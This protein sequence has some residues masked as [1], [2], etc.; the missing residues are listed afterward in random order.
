MSDQV[1][2]PL[3][4]DNGSA[5]KRSGEIFGHPTCL[6]TLFF[7][8]MW[9]RFSFYGM[10]ALLILYMVN[11]LFWKQEGASHVMAWYAGLVYATPVI[12]GI[13]ADKLIGARWAVVVGGVIIAIGHFLLAFEPM[14]FFYSG[15]GC[16]IVG[17]GF[18]KPNISTQVGALYR[19]NDERR[20]S[21][22]TIFYMGINLGAFI[23]PLVCGWLRFNY[24]YHYGFAAA[25]V[26]MVLGLIVYIWGMGRVVRRE[27]Q[28]A[29]EEKAA[30]AGRE[31]PAAAE[32]S[33]P[34]KP[35]SAGGPSQSRVYFDRG[36]VLVVICVFA[37][38]FWVGFEQAANVMNLWADKHT[39]LH[40]F[41]DQA[42]M[43][44]VNDVTAAAAQPSND[45]VQSSGGGIGNWQM[46]AEQSQ[47]INPLFIIIFAGVFAWLWEFLDRRGKQPSTPMKMAFGVFFLSCAYG[48]MLL[49]AQAEN[50]ASSA[51]LAILPEGLQ[52]DE[53]NRVCSVETTEDEEERTT[54]GATRLQWKDGTLR[55]NGVL[56]DLDWMRALSVTCTESYKQTI[57]DL[58]KQAEDKAEEVRLAKK[59]GTM[60]RDAGWEV[61]VEVPPEAGEIVFIAD[62]PAHQDGRETLPIASW[63]AESRT[64][65]VSAKLSDKDQAQLLAAG[66]DPDFQAALTQIYQNSSVLKVSIGWLLAF[67]LVLTIGELCLSP[68][69][70]S[71][72]TKAAHPAYVGLFMG[73]WF[74]TTGAVANFLAHYAGG[75]WGTMLPGQYFI[76]FGVLGVIAT[77]IML[78]L[79]RVL[80]PMLHGIH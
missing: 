29:A 50:Q 33:A 28:I 32:P 41:Q 11:Y 9:E 12:G 10:K 71:L 31:K 24:G 51:Q 54:Y 69:G 63:N 46:T 13:I 52:I 27:K 79:L 22:F 66:S 80:R 37:I 70:L 35:E 64:L 3:P 8:E 59:A 73:L 43:A 57:D 55:M 72:V 15:L 75:Y 1:S 16:L 34:A 77:V 20:D 58:V 38:L 42:P 36:M 44:E 40:V 26:G 74:L 47:S 61:S 60:D 17:T 39:N 21:A 68:V 5:P 25:G 6:F 65:A 45:A 30:G 19:S 78:L 48:I 7:A 67:Y 14:P 56:T 18:L 49:A 2:G 62:L 4:I 23:G 53:Q 76:I